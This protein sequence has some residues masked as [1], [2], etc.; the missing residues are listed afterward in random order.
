MRE[1]AALS[2]L[3]A[4]I[5]HERLDR[6][7]PLH[8]PCRSAAES[9]D[10]ALYMERFATVN[11][12]AHL[13]ARPYLP[14]GEEPDSRYPY[15]LVT[16]R[17]LE[18][19]NAGTMTRRTDNLELLPDERLEIHSHDA[20]QLGVGEGDRVEISSRRG[21]VEL[22]ARVTDRVAPGQLFM[23]FHFPEAL[24]NA[25]TSDATDEVTDCP[26]YKVTAVSVRAT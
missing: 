4:G 26:E 1:L 15:V 17:R 14:P 16:G 23:A 22:P 12:R 5:S 10:A 18:H 11:G 2:P 8:W 3:Y 9:G 13:A 6:E 25:L 7:G 21:T 24:A 20:E 19:Y